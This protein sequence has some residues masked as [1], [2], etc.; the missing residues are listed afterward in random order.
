MTNNYLKAKIESKNLGKIS[1]DFLLEL[2]AHAEK[3]LF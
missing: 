3:S 2:G 1:G